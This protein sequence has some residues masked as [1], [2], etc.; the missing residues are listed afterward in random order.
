VT[1]EVFCKLHELFVLHKIEKH[2]S[3]FREHDYMSWEQGDMV[4]ARV[5]DLTYE[6]G[7]SALNII[8]SFAAP[9]RFIASTI[10]KSD[11]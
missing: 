11:G 5:R 4:K 10:A 6:L 7:E 2:L 1:Y 8:E 3:V 9:D